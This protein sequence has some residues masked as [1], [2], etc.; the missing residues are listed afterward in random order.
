MDVAEP[1]PTRH[2]TFQIVRMG[3]QWLLQALVEDE[4][5]PVY[6]IASEP[7]LEG[8]YEM[9]NWYTSTHPDS[10]FRHR[11]IVTRTT[12]EARYILAEGRLT[13]RRP[14][15]SAEKR[16][17]NADEIMDSLATIFLLPVEPEWLPIAE[18]AAKAVEAE[19]LAEAA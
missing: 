13:I 12:P 18:R 10:H 11:L 16:F 17:L 2:E 1:Q 5:R 4:W 6:S 8:H 7:W 9:A 19:K 14:D 15:G 3:P